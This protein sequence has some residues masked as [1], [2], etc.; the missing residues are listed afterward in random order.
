MSEYERAI[1]YLEDSKCD[2]KLGESIQEYHNEVLGIAIESMKKQIPRVAIET[3]DTINIDYICP[4][5][6]RLN[7]SRFNYCYHCGQAIIIREDY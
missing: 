1:E 2:Q 6:N 4:E 5:C 7:K 3:Q